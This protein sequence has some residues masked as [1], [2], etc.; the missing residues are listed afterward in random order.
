MIE[1]KFFEYLENNGKTATDS[2]SD[3][4]KKFGLKNGETA[5]KLWFRHKNRLGLNEKIGTQAAN[6]I[7][8]LEDQITQFSENVKKGEAELTANFR[9]EIKTLDELITKTKIDTSIWEVERYIQNFWGNKD[10]PNW[11]V[12]AWLVKKKSDKTDLLIDFLDKY[13]SK[14]QPLKPTDLLIN[15]RME[16]PVS[17]MISLAD[18]HIDK[19]EK[20]GTTIQDK[21]DQYLKILNNLIYKAY[22]SHN[23]DEIVY[24]LGNDFF[25]SDTYWGTTTALTPQATTDEY[26][27]AYEK[28]FEL[29]INAINTLKQFCKKLKVVFVPANHDRSKSFYLVHALSVFFAKDENISFDRTADNTKAHR[30]GVTGLFFHHGDTPVASLPLYMATKYREMWGEVKYSEVVLGDKHHKK[31]WKSG[32][33]DGELDGTRM[34][35]CPALTGPDKWHTDKRYDHAI[36][37]GICRVY[38]FEEGF[39]AEFESRV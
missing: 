39:C 4:A 14:Y 5:R 12:K 22:M 35:I 1:Q 23:I 11:Q 3:L 37:A 2:W 16:K 9:E 13:E 19:V 38:D 8:E 6:Y 10:N 27:V 18:P 29:C 7:S 21:C 34:F 24:V 15:N 32:L 20:A 26:D 33:T 17:V 31:Q 25:T 36:Q 30:Y 28:G